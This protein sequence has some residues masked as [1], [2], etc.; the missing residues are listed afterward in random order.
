M[1][2]FPNPKINIG[3]YVTQK[4]EDGFHN[5]ETI[6]YPVDNKKDK[7]EI[8]LSGK[9]YTEVI[10]LS[11]LPVDTEN[12]ICLKAYNVLK[13]DFELPEVEIRLTKNIPM[14]AGLGG[15]SSDAAFTLKMLNDMAGLRLC[16]DDL[17]K[18]AALL[19]SDVPFFI[20]NKPVIAGGR[21]E[22]MEA[23][24]IDLSSKIITIVK[25]GIFISTAEAYSLIKPSMPDIS[26]RE[27]ISLP[28]EEWKETIRNDFEK[29]IFNQYPFLKTLKEELYT[30]GADYVSLTGSGSAIYAIADY[31][32]DHILAI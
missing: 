26:L 3:L 4:R 27:A 32:I 16:A 9:G 29:P 17:K 18:Y 21:G 1:V 19:G 7:I 6:F 14:G 5:L 12:N 11:G 20:E 10:L 24:D 8:S 25:P 31:S 15:G 30:L 13:R 23:V 22:I 2:C 28:V